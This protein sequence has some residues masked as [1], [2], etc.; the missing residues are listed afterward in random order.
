MPPDLNLFPRQIWATP[1][2]TTPSLPRTCS[3]FR[4]PSGGLLNIGNSTVLTIT[5]IAVFQ[6]ACTGVPHVNSTPPEADSQ[7][8]DDQLPF[9]ASTSPQIYAIAV[10]TVISYMLVLILFITPRT[11]FAGG[12][13]GGGGFLGRKGIISRTSGSASVIGAEG[14]PW[15]QKAAALTVAVSLTYASVDTFT[16]AQAQYNDGYQ[17]ALAL[18]DSVVKGTATKVIRLLSDIFLWL[19]QAQT[20]IKLFPRHREKIVIEWT[21]LVLITLDTIFS[22]LNCFLYESIKI[23]PR[24]FDDAIPALSYLFSSALSLIYAAMVM[25]YSFQKGRFAY[26][27]PKMRNICLL[28]MLSL[29]AI[30]IPLVFFILDIAKPNVAGWGNYAR[31]VG[32]AAASVVV[33]EWVER[34]EA[35]EAEERKDG[36][37]GREIFDGDEMLEVTPSSEVS[38]LKVRRDDQWGHGS[39]GGLRD[40]RSTGWTGPATAFGRA[41]RSRQGDRNL[42]RTHGNPHALGQAI[43][44]GGA[45]YPTQPSAVVSPRSRSGVT[46]AAS[47]NHVHY[48]IMSEYDQPKQEQSN[49]G[50]E[51]SGNV[52][53][54]R[55]LPTSTPTE[56]SQSR[57]TLMVKS[58]L[59]RWPMLTNIFGQDRRTPPP[60]VSQGLSRMTESSAPTQTTQTQPKANIQ[61][62][63]LDRLRGKTASNSGGA[64]V[65]VIIIPAPPPSGRTSF[66]GK[67]GTPEVEEHADSLKTS[68]LDTTNRVTQCPLNAPVIV[69]EEIQQPMSLPSSSSTHYSPPNPD[70]LA[71]SQQSSRII[72]EDCW[73][74]AAQSPPIS[75]GIPRDGARSPQGLQ[76][77]QEPAPSRCSTPP[78][79]NTRA[80]PER[81]ASGIARFYNETQDEDRI[82]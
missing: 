75:T 12:V 73:V 29:I 78:G 74:N 3:P 8:F 26:F 38:W 10:A 82:A 70:G 15:L 6:P 31:W 67:R 4:L 61:L 50:L 55:K 20:L 30:L 33:W 9:Y 71:L 64:S 1:T 51:C 17:D 41:P 13:G 49:P 76:N 48:H 32:A 72:S 69:P 22:A 65:P 57:K 23:R 77:H 37:L 34:I 47:T 81:P 44:A 53:Q 25:F 43:Q 11:L 5:D 60:E 59:S 40:G 27:H 2:V 19:A 58:F 68:V 66:I 56:E 39:G 45:D 18:T 42:E 35:L 52:Q 36:I 14:R 16:V 62:G 7:V 46:S 79:S 63:M 54:Q 80:L 21:G 24:N 28:A